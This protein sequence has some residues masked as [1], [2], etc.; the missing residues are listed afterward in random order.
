ML[1]GQMSI[2]AICS[3]GSWNKRSEIIYHEQPYH[4]DSR[5][6]ALGIVEPCFNVSSILFSCYCRPPSFAFRMAFYAVVVTAYL[7]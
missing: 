2:E 6:K 3:T 4:P 7:L 5:K 1:Q